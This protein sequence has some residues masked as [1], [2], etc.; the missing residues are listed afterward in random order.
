VQQKM[1][2]E[3]NTVKISDE[4]EFIQRLQKGDSASYEVL[5]RNYGGKMLAVAKRYFK[6]NSDAED[7][8][9]DAYIQAFRSIHSFE[10]RASLYS[11]LHRIVIN[12]AFMKIRGRK[13]RPEEFIDDNQAL[14][15]AQ[16]KRFELEDEITLSIE[17]MLVD[18]EARLAVRGHIKQL[19]ETLRNL[20]LLRDIE[21]YSTEQAAELLGASP[22]AIKTG[23]HRARKLLKK[24]IMK[25]A[26]ADERDNTLSILASK[27][28][29]A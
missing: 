25:N 16:G 6:N 23:L 7:C 21:G 8:V 24:R 26:K 12:A 27:R 5:V 15:D 10:G 1:N 20:L 13:R 28:S 14:F 19:P 22:G 29:T 4:S 18:E 9:Q 17:D 3:I 11:W 2:A